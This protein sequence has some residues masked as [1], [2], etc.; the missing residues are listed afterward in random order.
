[1]TVEKF[2][3]TLRLV[4]DLDRE[5]QLQSGLEAIN[6]ALANLVTSPAQ[7]TYQSTL[8]SAIAAFVSSVEKL[9]RSLTP[10][11]S[12]SIAEIGGTEFFDPPDCR[13]SAGFDIGKRDDSIG[14]KRFRSGFGRTALNLFDNRKIDLEGS[15]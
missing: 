8:A 14:C 5:L 2:Y 10:A 6:A 4:V 15:Q 12:V 3:E 11:Q 1:M 7:P 13:K 9:N